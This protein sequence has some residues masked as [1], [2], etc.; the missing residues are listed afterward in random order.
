MAAAAGDGVFWCREKSSKQ[1][2]RKGALQLL[3][4]D[5]IA[6]VE[7]PMLH[8]NC[9][10]PL[11]HLPNFLLTMWLNRII[12]IPYRRRLPIIL[13]LFAPHLAHSTID[14]E[15]FFFRSPLV[16]LFSSSSSLSIF[17]FSSQRQVA[18]Q[19]DLFTSSS[20]QGTRESFFVKLYALSDQLQR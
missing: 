20:R 17:F 15:T 16:S 4:H 14:I 9:D 12:K 7:L 2:V 13:Q 1:T 11:A 8:C 18:S 3:T 5:A 6:T 10:S 19:G